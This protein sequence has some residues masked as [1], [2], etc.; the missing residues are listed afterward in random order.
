VG[1]ARHGVGGL[2]WRIRPLGRLAVGNVPDGREHL[3][4]QVVTCNASF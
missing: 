4:S 3:V 2:A 1:R